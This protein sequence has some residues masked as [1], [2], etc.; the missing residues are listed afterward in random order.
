MFQKLPT[1][2]CTKILK[3]YF[4]YVVV[5]LLGK[6]TCR[7]DVSTVTGRGVT[8]VTYNFG[9]FQYN[10]ST[11]LQNLKNRITKKNN[12]HIIPMINILYPNY[13]PPKDFVYIIIKWTLSQY[14]S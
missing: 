2:L 1:N 12:L 7:N 13:V 14:Y 3:L 11:E 5:E 9:A 10:I 6:F 8:V 4:G